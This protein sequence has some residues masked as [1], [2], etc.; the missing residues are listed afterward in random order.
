[1]SHMEFTGKTVRDAIAKACEELEVDEALLDVEVSK[2]ALGVFLDWWGI[3][4][5]ES[6]CVNVMS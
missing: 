6:E 2:K 1:M 3:E 5:Q 4:T